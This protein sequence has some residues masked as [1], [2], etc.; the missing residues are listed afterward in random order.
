MMAT[1]TNLEEVGWVT[2]GTCV[3]PV[4][5][6]R[7]RTQRRLQR[8]AVTASL[9]CTLLRCL[10]SVPCVAWALSLALQPEAPH[11]A[12]LVR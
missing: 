5:L 12:S 10:L 2:K 1:L 4:S 9:V 8:C 11:I 3:V 7:T 6:G